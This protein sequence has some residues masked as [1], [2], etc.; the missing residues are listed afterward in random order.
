MDFYL[1][2]GVDCDASVQQV[3]RAYTRLAR[4][5]HPDIN[6]G[7]REAAAFYCRATEAYD[8]LCDSERR[9]M[10]DTHGHTATPVPG[11]S[12]EFHGFDF[13]APVSGASATF[14]ELFS[15]VLH[16]ACD[17]EAIPAR[18]GSDLHVDITLGFEEALVAVERRMMVTR[19]V[20]CAACVG[21]GARRATE[22]SCEDC[23]GAGTSLWRRGH[24]VFTKT[25][26]TCGGTG[27]QRQQPCGLCRADGVVSQTDEIIIQIPAGVADG[28]RMR[29]LENGH[30]GRGGG[31]AGDLYITARVGVHRLFVRDGN[32]LRL[33]VP[34][35][36]IEAV[37]G[38]TFDVPA[39]DGRV[40]L[41]IPPGTS[42]GQEFRVKNYG[43]PSPRTRERGDLIVTVT[44]VLPRVKDQR[45]KELLQ[46][47]EQIHSTDVRSDLF[48]E[49]R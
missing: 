26:S 49:Y 36:V 1:I 27:R 33:E 18:T 5:Y 24:M 40:R 35:T 38:A 7:D 44:L 4:R 29:V 48:V 15:E 47:F 12:I 8:T 46:E 13:S 43:A 37:L 3:K 32:D 16:E 19:L 6:P 39:V 34:I 25:C 14:A 10:Y 22:T 20:A 2:L 9:K 31:A 45:S 21:T 28:A 30:A 42:S 17:D 23:A 41:R 11:A